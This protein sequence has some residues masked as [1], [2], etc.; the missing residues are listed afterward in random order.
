[1]CWRTCAR[2]ISSGTSSIKIR[3][4]RSSSM[5]A[6]GAMSS[7]MK[8]EATASARFHPPI[9][10]TIA[11]MMTAKDPKASF[12]TSRTAARILSEAWRPPIST[13]SESA[14]ATKPKI[15]THSMGVAW[16][17]TGE[18]KRWMPSTATKRL[19]MTNM[20]AWKAAARTSDRAHPHVRRLSRGRKASVVAIKAMTS[21][22]ESTAI[23]PASAAR[24]KEDVKKAATSSAMKIVAV[25]ASAIASLLR[26]AVCPCE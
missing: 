2:S 14:F 23:C 1:M 4:V 20:P 10:S 6:R 26:D 5:Q 17:S 13:N 24:D 8:I 7:A 21:P 22:A 18:S 19:M 16:T 15:P 3:R 11:A 25:I 12:A 9:N